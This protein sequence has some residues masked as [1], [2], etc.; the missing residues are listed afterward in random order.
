[1]ALDRLAAGL[2][3]YLLLALLTLAMAL[4]GI[5]SI[6]PLDRDE[7]RFA[8]ASREMIETEDF[9]T[10]RF[11]DEIRAKK[12]PLINWLQ[13]ETAE[14]TG[15]VDDI[16]A[17][18]IPSVI[19][20]LAAVLAT[21]YFGRAMLGAPA[22]L[23]AAALLA[24]TPLA[25]SE[26]HQAKTDALLLACVVIAQGALARFYL[27]ERRGET[28]PGWGTALAF[29]LAQAA[30]ILIKGPILPMVSALT[31]ITLIA[32]DRRAPRAWA[33]LKGLRPLPGVALVIILVAPWAIAVSLA[34]RGQFI[35]QAVG[36]DLVSK[37]IGGQEAHAA[38]P[39]TYLL[40]ATATL[41][42]GSIFILPGLVRAVG[43]RADPA[44]RF[45]LDPLGQTIEQLAGLA[46]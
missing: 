24:V 9:V 21:F 3:P 23:I 25:A 44:I 15:H 29:W 18:R 34:T 45:F 20:I 12:P 14:L 31:I 17:Y 39:G 41:W 16:W 28:K 27:A 33:W 42:P 6:P 19:G 1:M 22:A 2:R 11:Q 35:A 38:A 40:L 8:V 36:N 13:A 37:L 26:A 10:V 43:A 46:S 4:P 32:A 7:S 30:A 5:A